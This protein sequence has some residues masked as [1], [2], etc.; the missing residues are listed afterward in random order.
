MLRKVFLFICFCCIGLSV[1]AQNDLNSFSNGADSLLQARMNARDAE[2]L[3][4]K[5][6]YSAKS[7]R[8]TY[9]RNFKYNNIVF[10]NPDTIPDNMH[11]VSY[12]E[13]NNYLIQNLGNI[14]TAQR[15]LFYEVPKVIGR[16]SGYNAYNPFY[17]TPDQIRYYDTRSPYTDIKAYFAGGGRAITDIT[18]TLNDST[19]FNIGGSF[20]ALRA[21]KQ[22]AYL[23]R[24]DRQ[25]TSN[26]WNIFGFYRPQKLKK[27][28]LLFNTTQFKHTVQE[29]GGII[30]PA[31]QPAP[32]NGDALSF[33]DYEDANVYLDG[34]ESY[35]KRGG[36]H[37][38]QQYDLDSIFQVY[39]TLDYVQQIARYNDDYDL[40]G[41]DRYIYDEVVNT[42]DSTRTINDRNFFSDFSNEFG[43]KGRTK[44]FSYTAYY[45]NRILK[46]ES[47]RSS[48]EAYSSAMEA[49]EVEHYVGGT[50]R[51]QITP[52]VFLKA[53][54]EFMFDGNYLIEGDFSSD[55][56]DAKYS[57]VVSQPSFLA[58][59]YFQDGRNWISGFENETSDNLE[60]TIKISSN[61]VSF[62]PFLRFNRI[63]NYIF[64]NQDRVA[65]QANSD[66]ILL[67]PG[68]HFDYA[69]TP[70]LKWSNSVRYN[71]ISGGSASNY[72]LPQFMALSQLAFKN[73]IFDGKM[74]VHTGIDVF[75][76][77]EYEPLAY[78]PII[79]QFYLQDS[80][81]SDDFAKIDLFVNFK[82]GNFM[83]LA[84]M[85]HVNQLG[86][87]GY[88]I[89]PNYT[90]ARR[91]LDLGVRWLF[92]D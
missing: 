21:E 46:N 4:N 25:V 36:L 12:Y 34:A 15:S 72:K 91:T 39:H 47:L 27:Y 84:K 3:R 28:L 90:G 67:T 53:T 41:Y 82:V 11:R 88:F 92:F 54:G 87:N 32:S 66:I 1:S 43:L 26:D 76:Q 48:S 19:Q 73:V 7:T 71:S 2:A 8:F 24:G 35:D 74:I 51:Q 10:Q 5:E 38:Y 52:K 60:G 23:T 78:D 45:R 86:T 20:K 59:F 6:N 49:N 58:D 9:E 68:L 14:G 50:L 44:K 56:F 57:R 75:Y 63:S 89:S 16:T 79:Q 81:V 80:F 83:I 65:E 22:L 77:T 13:S 70:K 31:L 61:R 18:F 30:D 37:L 64:F 69:I 85:G 33:F 55:W 42:D 40:R 29:Q 17:T 62:R